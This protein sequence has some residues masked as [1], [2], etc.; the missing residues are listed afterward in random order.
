MSMTQSL[1]V[2]NKKYLPSVVLAKEFNY[3]SDYISKLARDEKILGTR[4]GRQWFVEPES[5]R[6]FILQLEVEKKLV[7]E[8]LSLERKRERT[9][10]SRNTHERIYEI[11]P[12]IIVGGK[13]VAVVMCGFILG[14]LLLFTQMTGFRIAD[15]ASGS[16]FI[17]QQFHEKIASGFLELLPNQH[18]QFNSIANPL[19]SEQQRV[20]APATVETV[21]PSEG[22]Y[23]VFPDIVYATTTP[24]VLPDDVRTATQLPAPDTLPFSDEV[25]FEE[26][27]GTVGV[28]PVFKDSEGDLYELSLTALESTE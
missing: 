13:S 20:V 28:R 10:K 25:M 9:E 2:N 24:V 11:E 26:H 5:L 23:T 7:K 16:Q 18:N 6:T 1:E 27:E 14:C 19:L 3:T 15:V 12:A 8:E 4:I 17:G 21:L 22:V